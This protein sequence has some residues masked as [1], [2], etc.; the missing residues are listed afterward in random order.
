MR[1]DLPFVA[2]LAVAGLLTALLPSPVW[3]RSALL[4]PL[5]LFLPGYALAANLF[6]PRTVSLVE[7]CVYAVVLS[8]SVTAVGGLIAQLVLDLGRDVWAVLLTAV[9]VAASIRGY[10]TSSRAQVPPHLSLRWSSSLSLA[11]LLGAATLAGLAIVSASNGLHNSQKRIRFTSFW[12]LPAQAEPE[13]VLIGIRSHEGR[14]SHYR[15]R[16]ERDGTAVAAAG[17][18]LASGQTWERQFR[19]PGPA[20]TPVLAELSKAGQP[21]RHLDL[22]PRP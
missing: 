6:A 17:I 13:S 11:V 3:L 22:V 9:T 10:L 16:L 1:R 12:M 20:G 2:G 14:L 4:I 18:R 5:V 8:I 15:L 7:R 21:Y 19:V